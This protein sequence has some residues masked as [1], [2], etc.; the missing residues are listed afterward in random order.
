M[1]SLRPLLCPPCALSYA[2]PVPC[3]PF[4]CAL[5][6]LPLCPPAVPILPRL[7]SR[8]PA[9]GQEQKQTAQFHLDRFRHELS[10]ASVD[11]LSR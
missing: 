8:Q 6:S 3:A 7:E 10:S 11:D 5:C 9:M 4:P 2:P 1:P